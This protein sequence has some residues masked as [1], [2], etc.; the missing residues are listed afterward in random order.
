MALSTTSSFSTKKRGAC[1]RMI[2]SLLVM[3]SASTF[4]DTGAVGHGPGFDLPG[5]QVVGEG[6][7][8]FGDTLVI[9]FHRADPLDQVG[10]VLADHNGGAASSGGARLRRCPSF[11]AAAGATAG[12]CL[13]FHFSE[14]QRL[15]CAAFQKRQRHPC[16]P[17]SARRRRG[18]AWLMARSLTTLL[19]M[20]TVRVSESTPEVAPPF[21]E[22]GLDVG[23]VAAAGDILE[24]L[25]VDGQGE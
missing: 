3:T 4:A 11:M 8:D 5:G 21:P 15:S 19:F 1:R 18:F 25:V 23:H 22:V 9:G 7:R 14:Q 10:E 13:L 16:R 2:R 6:D 17:A 12:I 24:G 20:M